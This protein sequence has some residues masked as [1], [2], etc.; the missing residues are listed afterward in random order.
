VVDVVEEA[1]RDATGRGILDRAADD[2]RCF[3]QEVEVV[4][5]RVEG[6][7]GAGHE[8]CEPLGDRQGRLPAVRLRRDLEQAPIFADDGLRSAVC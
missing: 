5:R 8:R 6:A 3:R 2:G 1:D 7:L 4:L